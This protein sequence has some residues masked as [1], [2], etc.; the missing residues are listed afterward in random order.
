MFFIFCWLSV[1]LLSL[2]CKLFV[3]LSRSHFCIFVFPGRRH[4]VV[5][6]LPTP[7]AWTFG[8]PVIRRHAKLHIVHHIFHPS[9]TNE[10]SGAAARQRCEHIAIAKLFRS[11]LPHSCWGAFCVPKTQTFTIHLQSLCRHSVVSK[12]FDYLKS[13]F[14][15]FLNSTGVVRF[16]EEISCSAIIQNIPLRLPHT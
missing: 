12:F 14:C 7:A 11:F 4:P 13:V 16:F 1:H 15:A 3:Y 9:F 10:A 8:P 2:R 6:L 5:L